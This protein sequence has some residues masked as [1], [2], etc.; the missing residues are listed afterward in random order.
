MLDKLTN[1]FKKSPYDNE[2][3]GNVYFVN[4]GRYKGD[5]YVVVAFNEYKLVMFNL[6][7]G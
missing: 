6:T 2:Y 4:A 7:P 5:Y 3:E 1:L